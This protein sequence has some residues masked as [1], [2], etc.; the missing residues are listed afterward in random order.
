MLHNALGYQIP[1]PTQICPDGNL[2]S[3]VIPAM[4]GSFKLFQKSRTGRK[5]RKK[6]RLSSE[7]RE[8]PNACLVPL[9]VSPLALEIYECYDDVVKHVETSWRYEKRRG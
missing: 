4:D 5:K 7:R 3:K 1:D 6:R 9:A 2:A 8:A